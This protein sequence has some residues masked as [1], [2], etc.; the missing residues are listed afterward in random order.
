MI[1]HVTINDFEIGRRMVYILDDDDF[2][3]QQKMW[4]DTDDLLLAL[5]PNALFAGRTR[6][7]DLDIRHFHV[8]IVNMLKML[9]NMD[10]FVRNN[11]KSQPVMRLAFFLCGLIALLQD[12]TGSVVELLR[13]NRIS[14][15]DVVY[16]YS[17]SLDVKI[18]ASG[19]RMGLKLV[20][21]N[22]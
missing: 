12:Q 13:M 14:V 6:W 11:N 21:D 18:V 17:A 1:C 15:D 9:G 3:I 7:C 10:E 22:D 2:R 16:D 8:M 19:P 5:Q 20:V 4:S